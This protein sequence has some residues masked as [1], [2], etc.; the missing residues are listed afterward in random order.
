MLTP[1]YN[2]YMDVQQNIDLALVDQLAAEGVDF[3]CPTQTVLVS[4]TSR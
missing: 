1:D 3:A 4:G 2:S